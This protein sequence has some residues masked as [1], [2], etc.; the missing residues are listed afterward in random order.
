MNKS[1]QEAYRVFDSRTIAELKEVLKS[2][3]MPVSGKKRDLIQYLIFAE[4]SQVE[5][6]FLLEAKLGYKDQLG[7]AYTDY[8]GTWLWAKYDLWRT[9]SGKY[10]DAI[11]HQ[12][13]YS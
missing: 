5:E 13:I 8:P 3:D 12:D 11:N 9:L 4:Y 7:N 2:K 1:W 6:G 10:F